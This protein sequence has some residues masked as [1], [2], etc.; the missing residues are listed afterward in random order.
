MNSS[1]QL[2]TGYVM[3]RR[4][5]PV[6]HA[7]RYP[8][9][10]VTLPLRHLETVGNALFGI[11]RT[12]PLS[13]RDADHGPLDGSALL[14]W[15]ESLLHERGLPCDGEIL[16][17]TFPRL[18][19]YV[20]NPV[21]F[22]FCHDRSGALIVVLAE[23]NNTFG[24][25]HHY[26]LHNS[27]GSPLEAKQVLVAR[28]A[29]HVSP[30]CEVKG[31]Y[32]FRF[33]VGNELQSS[34]IDYDDGEGDLLLTSISGSTKPL[35][36]TTLLGALLRMPLLTVDVIVRIHWQAFRLWLKGVRFHGKTPSSSLQECTK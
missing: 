33:D 20:F 35:T 26:L 15:I 23:V 13:F 1:A 2:L 3:H 16:L 29:L 6:E 7:F 12:R 28:K 17:Q 9:F 10:Y 24:G 32:R 30:F 34:S 31:N 18:F 4:L 22:W 11:N 21:S 8:V 19:G 14:P 5:R 27:D 25:H 36:V